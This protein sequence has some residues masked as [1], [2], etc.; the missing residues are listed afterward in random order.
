MQ[1]TGGRVAVAL[2]VVGSVALFSYAAQSAS[3]APDLPSRE[4]RLSA[5]QWLFDS[6]KQVG[7]DM[8]SPHAWRYSFTHS[9]KEPLE[10]AGQLLESEGYEFV[11][12]DF[13]AKPSA[14]DRD[15]WRLQVE[16]VEKHSV[17]SLDAR[18]LALYR[19]AEDNGLH[20][21]DGVE[22]G[23]PDHVVCAVVFTHASTQRSCRDKAHAGSWK[24]SGLISRRHP[25]FFH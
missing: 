17:R 9:S 5:L 2:C 12:I 13:I 19:F 24:T 3:S 14:Y 18:V 4:Q 7:W 22:V 6:L 8:S 10:R 16:K 11:I 20:S 25:E 23:R 1:I 15:W 21:F